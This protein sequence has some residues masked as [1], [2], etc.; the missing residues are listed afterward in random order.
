MITS[1]TV[2]ALWGGVFLYGNIFLDEQQMTQIALQG[3]LLEKSASFCRL[4]MKK[5]ATVQPVYKLY[6]TYRHVHSY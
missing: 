4:Q 6:G 1:G 3:A 5:K 2:D